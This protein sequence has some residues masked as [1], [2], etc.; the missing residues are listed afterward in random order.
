MGII[1][2]DDE[3]FH[4]HPIIQYRR[5]AGSDPI[6]LD[7]ILS[8][9]FEGHLSRRQRYLIALLVASSVGQ[10]QSTPW[11]L[12]GL[13][14]EDIIFFPS[15]DDSPIIPYGEPFIRQGFPHSH[16][17]LPSTDFSVNDCNFYSLGILLLELCFGCR[18]ED[19]HLYKKHPSTTDAATKHAFDVMAALK[20]SS[21]VSGEG[22]D[23]Y[24][25]AVKW[26]FTGVTDREKNW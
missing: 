3:I 17:H 7:H 1:S 10:L 2:H 20:W 9:D 12:T 26:C 14:K 18:L 4:L 15:N 24:A 21:S 6:T 16:T 8:H 11:L 22:G 25:T 5:D 19:H 13:C 23:D